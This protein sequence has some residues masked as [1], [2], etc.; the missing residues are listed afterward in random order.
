MA[1]TTTPP[2]ARTRVPVRG[3]PLARNALPRRWQA[4]TPRLI[5]LMMVA[6]VVAALAWGAVG[7]WTVSQHSAAASNVV[8]VREPLS[9]EARGLYQSLSDADVTATTAF[10]SG[11]RESLAMRQRY[12]A[13]I[14]QAGA[15]LADLSAAA[16]AGEP[17]LDASLRTVA[18]GLPVYTGYVAQAQTDFLLGYQLTGG[19]FTQVASEQMHLVLLPAARAIYN[20]ANADLAARSAQ[21]TGLPWIAIMLVIFACL[22]F[23][24]YRAQRWLSR[25]T[26]RTFNVG[27][28]VTSLLLAMSG[29]WL[30]TSFYVARSDLQSAEVHGSAPEEALA[31]SAIA[32]QHARGDE[33]LNLISRSGSTSFSGDFN[34]IRNQVGPGPGALLTAAARANQGSEAAQPTAAA[35]ADARAWYASGDKVFSLDVAASY[36]AET[37]LVIGTGHGSSAAAFAQLESDLRTAIADDQGVFSSGAAAGANAFTGLEAA[38]IV[39]AAAMA[40]GCAW[41]LAQR[42]REYG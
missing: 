28:L 38:I 7:A 3:V 5:A 16:A 27:L 33:I 42:L 26:R 21:A 23:G 19:S 4:S 2:A 18:T 40:A 14:A 35:Q 39:A 22:G 8:S 32:I 31:E 12:Q 15:V 13:D 24:L 10:L 9:V 6:L 11:P 30:L 37:G 25:R 20:Q 1:S 34:A 29:I 36:R 41:G 17:Q